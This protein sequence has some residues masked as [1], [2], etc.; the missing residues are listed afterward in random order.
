M[1]GLKISRIEDSGL[2]V[3]ISSA[4]TCLVDLRHPIETSEGLQRREIG[5]GVAHETVTPRV[6]LWK[7][8]QQLFIMKR[9]WEKSKESPGRICGARS[10]TDRACVPGSRRWAILGWILPGILRWIRRFWWA[11]G[12]RSGAEG[13]FRGSVPVLRRLPPG[14]PGGELPQ[15]VSS[16]A[17]VSPAVDAVMDNN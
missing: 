13:G 8:C 1:N 14:R 3:N 15:E 17:L 7:S 9:R 10:S 4:F 2:D 12:R 16:V 6:R 11:P 5:Q